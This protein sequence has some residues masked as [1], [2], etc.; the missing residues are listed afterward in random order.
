MHKLINF[1][2]NL[3]EEE[4]WDDADLMPSQNPELNPSQNADIN[5]SQN[6][7]LNSSQNSNI[8]RTQNPDWR[9]NQWELFKQTVLWE[10]LDDDQREKCKDF[11]RSL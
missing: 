3:L 10:A 8:N 6:A 4:N 2:V 7:E 1:A 9:K 11:L 5:T